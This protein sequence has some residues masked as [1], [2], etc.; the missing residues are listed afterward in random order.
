MTVLDTNYL[1]H[2]VTM[3]GNALELVNDF[4][5]SRIFQMMS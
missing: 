2:L 1:R 5:G 4:D 3:K